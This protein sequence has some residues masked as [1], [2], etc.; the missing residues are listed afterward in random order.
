[1]AL[2]FNFSDTTGSTPTHT[3]LG[4]GVASPPT[5]AIDFKCV[6]TTGI[7]ASASEAVAIQDAR[8]FAI[9]MR[10]H[11]AGTFFTCTNVKVWL[12]NLSIATWG[13]GASITGSVQTVYA[14]PTDNTSTGDSA[15]PTTSAT[16]LDVS[17]SGAGTIAVGTAGYSKYWRMQANV[18]S[19]AT[20]GT[21]TA[22][23]YI[24]LIYSET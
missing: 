17:Q 10:G 5:H 3:D 22:S 1:M 4:T 6:N 24:N 13:T 16:A 2:T 14:Q 15:M 9:W 20:S 18:T 8:S 7:I 19:D 11:M 23:G 21:Y 12:S